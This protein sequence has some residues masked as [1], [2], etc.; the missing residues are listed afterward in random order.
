[1]YRD[2]Y[3]CTADLK[4]AFELRE[5][6]AMLG[7][8]RA[9][10]LLYEM[11]QHGF[12]CIKDKTKSIQWLTMSANL[13]EITA[14]IELGRHFK[15]TKPLMA[16]RYYTLASENA[17][18]LDGTDLTADIMY[19]MKKPEVMRAIATMIPSEVSV[20]IKDL[21]V[22]QTIKVD[23]DNNANNNANNNAE[24]SAPITPTPVAPTSVAPTSSDANDASYITQTIP[25]GGCWHLFIA[26]RVCEKN[27]WG[28]YNYCYKRIYADGRNSIILCG[29]CKTKTPPEKCNDDVRYIT[30]DIMR[31]SSCEVC[32][33]VC[34]KI[35]SVNHGESYLCRIYEDGRNDM[36][37]CRDC[38]KP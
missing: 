24:A 19:V 21:I 5:R 8:T 3:G 9:M 22:T 25:Q 36:P 33:G 15:D 12:G 1:M 10:K 38:H 35:E 13:G 28:D 14:Q 11:Y 32:C 23:K 4:R 20:D 17:R 37:I 18:M 2:G 26:C 27:V 30:K 34:A 6:A 31:H 16:L 29:D 7:S